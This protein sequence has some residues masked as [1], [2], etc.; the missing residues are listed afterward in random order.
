MQLHHTGSQE[1]SLV[2]VPEEQTRPDPQDLRAQEV[3][4]EE[5]QGEDLPEC[6]DHQ[7]SL[8]DR[9]KP[10]SILNSLFYSNNS[11]Y[12]SYMLMH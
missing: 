9:G 7:P 10:W 3:L 5:E 2:A 6:V 8:F 1:E 12:M 11:L 4:K